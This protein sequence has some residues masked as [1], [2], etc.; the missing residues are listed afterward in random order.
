M[1]NRLVELSQM[2]QNSDLSHVNL[3]GGLVKANNIASSS[4]AIF[5]AGERS[6]SMNLSNSGC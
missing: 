4:L 6:V 2:L 5:S 3:V 1:D